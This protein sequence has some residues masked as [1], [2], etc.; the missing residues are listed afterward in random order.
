MAYTRRRSQGPSL[1]VLLLI[2]ACLAGAFLLLTDPGGL[3]Q[4]LYPI[5]GG[6]NRA[7]AAIPSTA[8]QAS[9]PRVPKPIPKSIPAVSSAVPHAEVTQPAATAPPASSEEPPKADPSHARVKKDSTVA[10]SSTSSHSTVV[11]VL[12]KDATVEVTFELVNS[13]GRW[14]MVRTEGL[15]QPVFV[16]SE[17]LE[18]HA[19]KE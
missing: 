18:R 4:L 3:D 19:K 11:A 15:N 1:F 7:S 17:N 10:Y 9:A 16:R 6:R 5:T 12:D 13:E 2:A 8:T 14:T